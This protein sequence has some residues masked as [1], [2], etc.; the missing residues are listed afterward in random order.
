MGAN[1]RDASLRGADLRDANLRGADLTGAKGIISFTGGKDLLI[2]FKAKDS[3]LQINIGCESHS[4]THW[5]RQYKSIGIKHGYLDQEIDL[6][7]A[8][9]HLI[10][11]KL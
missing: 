8:M 6:Y 2:A 7:G 3:E 1:L 9:I 10:E 11:G 5:K 4:L